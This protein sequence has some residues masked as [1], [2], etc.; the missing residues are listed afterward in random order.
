MHVRTVLKVYEI[1]KSA[2]VPITMF[3]IR[4]RSN[5]SINHYSIRKALEFLEEMGK[6]ERVKTSFTIFWKVKD[7]AKPNS[8]PEK[9]G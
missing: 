5:Y 4:K 8:T 3:E 9:L 1:L 7:D 2:K 6:V